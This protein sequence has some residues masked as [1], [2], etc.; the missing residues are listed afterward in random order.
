MSRF[1][2]LTLLHRVQVPLKKGT[3]WQ[4]LEQSVRWKLSDE[5][6][7]NRA[8]WSLRGDDTLQEYFDWNKWDAVVEKFFTAS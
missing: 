5:R 3:T 2:N 6:I 1:S 4:E 7:W 8:G